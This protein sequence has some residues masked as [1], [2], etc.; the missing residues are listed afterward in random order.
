[1][2]IDQGTQAGVFEESEQDMVEGVFSLG[3]QRVYSLMTPRTEIVW[4]DIEDTI[5]EIRTKISENEYSR[6][7]LSARTPWMSSSES[8]RQGDMLVPSLSEG[9][10]SNSSSCSNPPSTSRK[11]CLRRGP[12]DLQGK[13]DGDAS[14]H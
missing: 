8:S 2:L 7:S 13:R 1:V 12:G 11:P 10:R 5:E 14:R 6:A 3:E 4:L 9:S